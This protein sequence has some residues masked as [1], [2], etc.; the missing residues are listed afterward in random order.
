M[1]MKDIKGL[2]DN[3]L[4]I[5]LEEVRKESFTLRNQAKTGQIENPAKLKQN[6]RSVARILTEQKVRESAKKN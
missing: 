5:Q 4:A 6:R 1:K 2:S 3:D